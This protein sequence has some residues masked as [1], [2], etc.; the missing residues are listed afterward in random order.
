MQKEAVSTSI[1]TIDGYEQVYPRLRGSMN[2]IK[3][4]EASSLIALRMTRK[5]FDRIRE[6]VNKMLDTS[7]KS[8]HAQNV[9]AVFDD[10][11]EILDFGFSKY[12]PKDN[13]QALEEIKKIAEKI[14][15]DI[16]LRS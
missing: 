11:I 10:D 12:S 6:K 7:N 15:M 2:I 1:T 13:R 8:V 3:E 5:Q 16:R 14:K 4:K 9:F